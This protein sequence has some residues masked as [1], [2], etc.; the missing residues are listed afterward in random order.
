MRT[1]AGDAMSWQIVDDYL[2]STALQQSLDIIG[3]DRI[4][5][6]TVCFPSYC[7]INSLFI[8]A[9][10]FSDWIVGFCMQVPLPRVVQPAAGAEPAHTAVRVGGVLSGQ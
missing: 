9:D 6:S 4:S 1:V 3:F 5:S 7:G 10:M 2:N 8:D